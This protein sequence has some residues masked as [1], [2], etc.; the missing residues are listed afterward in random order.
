M[1]RTPAGRAVGLLGRTAAVWNRVARGVDKA[2]QQVKYGVGMRGGQMFQGPSQLLQ[3]EL[4]S[5]AAGIAGA[6]AG[7]VTY[8][9]AEALTDQGGATHEDL[10]RVSENEIDKLSPVDQEVV[11]ASRARTGASSPRPLYLTECLLIGPKENA[12]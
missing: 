11:H 9:I 10:A 2:V 5:Q 1:I 4:K 3:T 6:G 8:G 12:A 7:S